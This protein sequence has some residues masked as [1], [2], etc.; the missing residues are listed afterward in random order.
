M[1]ISTAQF[2]RT[3]QK[4]NLLVSFGF[5]AVSL[6][7]LVSQVGCANSCDL[8]KRN[9][10]AEHKDYEVALLSGKQG[11]TIMVGL[12]SALEQAKLECSKP[13]LSLEEILLE[14]GYVPGSQFKK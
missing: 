7:L 1:P 12:Y 9:V 2:V 5:L 4:R 13:S 14:M 11:M 10:L 8:A 3:E 6:L